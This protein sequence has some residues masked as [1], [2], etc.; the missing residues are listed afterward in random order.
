MSRARLLARGRCFGQP[1]QTSIAAGFAFAEIKTVVLPI[2]AASRV[3]GRTAGEATLSRHKVAIDERRK[4]FPVVRLDDF[5][6]L[7]TSC[8]FDRSDDETPDQKRWF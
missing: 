3:D 6:E 1:K 7:D 2:R 8:G 4:P 5:D